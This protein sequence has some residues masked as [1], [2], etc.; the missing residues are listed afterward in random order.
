MTFGLRNSAQ[1]FQRFI[2]EVLRGLDFCFVYID[3]IL[4]ASTSFEE[5]QHLETVFQRLKDYGVVVNTPKYVFDRSEVR[6]LGYRVSSNG[7]CPLPER[8]DAIRGYN[9]PDTVKNLWQFLDMLNFY[10]RFIPN[11]AQLQTPLN[12]HLQDNVKGNIPVNLT[13]ASVRAFEACKESLAQATL[14]AHSKPDAPLALFTDAPILLWALPFNNTSMEP[15]SH[16]R[17]SPR[18]WGLSRA[19]I[20]SIRLRAS[21]YLPGY[22]TLQTYGRGK[23]LHGVYRS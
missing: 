6:F 4:I 10:R 1:T 17:S 13:A 16:W 19:Q 23:T 7:T 22:K 9:L 8:V 20:R 14:L 15:W 12:D 18:S 3:D 11:A 2:D 5:L 21:S